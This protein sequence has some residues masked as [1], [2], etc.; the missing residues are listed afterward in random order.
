MPLKTKSVTL[1]GQRFT[2]AQIPGGI[3]HDH[4]G[5]I[6]AH[7][8]AGLAKLTGVETGLLMSKD[9]A[10][11]AVVGMEVSTL[12]AA[13]HAVASRLPAEEARWLRELL[14]ASATC[15]VAGGATKG[16]LAALDEGEVAGGPL[17]IDYLLAHAIELSILPFSALAGNA[18]PMP[19][20]ESSMA[21]ST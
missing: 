15:T 12:G 1:N 20:A 7:L 2:I 6:V 19:P 3:A 5:R 4:H 11:A 8:T 9:T 10:M 14:L 21:S 18:P 13:L 17:A 16:V